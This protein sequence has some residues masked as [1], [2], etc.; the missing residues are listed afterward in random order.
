MRFLRSALEVARLDGQLFRHFPKLR[1]SV[2][3][4]VLI[5]ALYAFIYLESVWDP[6]S[7]TANLPAAIVNLDRGSRV[8]EEQVNLGEQLATKLKAQR[9]FGFYDSGDVEAARQSVRQGHSLFALII[10]ADFSAAALSADAAGA[11]KLVIFASEGN[12]YTGAGFAKRFASEAGHQLNE[13]L[14]EKRWAVVLGTAASSAD[15]LQRLR[16]GV[17]QLH[18]GALALD[19]GLVKARGGSAQ[20]AGG[21]VQLSGGVDALGDG[22]K[23]LGAG[24]RTLDARKPA[25]AD[26]RGLK[27]GATQLAAGHAE[28][29]KAMPQLEDGAQRLAKGAAQLRDETR[30]IPLVGGKVSAGAGQLADGAGQLQAGLHAATQGQAKLGAGAQEL[31]KGVAQ[32]S[33]GFAAYAA[34]VSQLAAKFPA[35]AKLDELGAGARTLAEGSGQLGSGVAQLQ[36]GSSRLAAGLGALAAALPASAPSLS[37]TA[38]GLAESVEPRIEIDAPVKNNGMGF[39]PNFIPVALWLGAV[40]TA[41]VFHLRRLPQAAARHSRPALLM[42]KLGI[43]GSINAAQALLVLLMS[44]FLLGLQP[45]HAAGLALVMVTSSITFMLIILLLVRAFGD[46]GKA[47]ALILLILQLSSAGGVMPIQLT[48]DFYRTVSPYLPFTWAVKGVRA[49][50]FGAFGGEWG[51]ALAVLACF[52]GGAFGL[53]L[54]VGRWKFVPPDEHRPA[55]DI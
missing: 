31:S 9:A 19:A 20:L 54:L 32:L 2:L 6:S 5:P 13:T 50:A 26:L 4:I 27:D 8:G 51:T 55:M 25:A 1:W 39:A 21:A 42:G 53:S 10:P 3:G 43:L 33:D 12:N 34:G 49:S 28:L 45:V 24:A 15:S 14:N 38:R 30:N 48:S 7:R 52:A 23:Q 35:D 37:G 36:A 18:E 41:F 40:M 47:L 29:G 22:V 11:G 16:E 44:W 17:A 46:A